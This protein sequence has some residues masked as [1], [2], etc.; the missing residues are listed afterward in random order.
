MHSQGQEVMGTVTEH[1]NID[2]G[3]RHRGGDLRYFMQNMNYCHRNCAV[4]FDATSLLAL[5]NLSVGL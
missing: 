4:V 2:E 5:A 1:V 3:Q